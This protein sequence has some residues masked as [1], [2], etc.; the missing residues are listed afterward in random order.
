MLGG[1]HPPTHTP[2]PPPPSAVTTLISF[3]LS[4]LFLLLKRYCIAFMNQ[5]PSVLYFTT[6]V[7]TDEKFATHQGRNLCKVGSLWLS[8]M[9]K[10][11]MLFIY[12]PSHVEEFNKKSVYRT[13]PTHGLKY[14][15]S[16]SFTDCYVVY[17]DHYDLLGFSM[18]TSVLG[19]L[20][21]GKV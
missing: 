21:D 11:K 2:P 16:K 6:S 14:T 12:L 17:L 19:A 5:Y 10:C 18:S 9:R 4:V 15:I 1:R 13:A 7:Y 8:H 3:F 20:R